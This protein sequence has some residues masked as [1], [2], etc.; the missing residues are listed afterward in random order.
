M[1]GPIIRGM[2]LR[3]NL[4]QNYSSK[5]GNSQ[6][7]FFV[8]DVGCKQYTSNTAKF[9][10]KWLHHKQQVERHAQQAAHNAQQVHQ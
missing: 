3:M 5:F 2:I 8:T 1:I 10:E 9:Y 4:V 6:Q 7:Q